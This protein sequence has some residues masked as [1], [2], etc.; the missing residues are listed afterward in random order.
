ML[1]WVVSSAPIL[2][3]SPKAKPI[4]MQ[5][6][7][8]CGK[9]NSFMHIKQIFKI[10]IQKHSQRDWSIEH[11]KDNKLIVFPRN[12]SLSWF[13]NFDQHSSGWSRN[14]GLNIDS[15]VISI[16]KP[17]FNFDVKIK[18]RLFLWYKL[19]LKFSFKKCRVNKERERE[20]VRFNILEQE[21][22][23][24]NYIYIAIQMWKI[25]YFRKLRCQMLILEQVNS[26]S[27]CVYIYESVN[28]SEQFYNSHLLDMKSVQ[29]LT[30][31]A[32]MYRNKLNAALTHPTNLLELLASSFQDM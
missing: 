3:P 18:S 12:Q 6:V 7:A 29:K 32:R 23:Y 21:S 10:I 13:F 11:I 14:H 26:K 25:L 9:V 16:W 20:C 4:H 15:M 28:N 31:L 2:N 27:K 5:H 17:H 8:S 24:Q 1:I 30:W 22:F 19:T